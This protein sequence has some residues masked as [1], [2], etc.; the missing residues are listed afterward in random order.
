MGDRISFEE[1]SLSQIVLG[2]RD[3]P[4]QIEKGHTNRGL[5]RMERRLVE[6][7]LGSLSP[8]ADKTLLA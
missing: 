8:L 3:L 6:E 5:Q 2:R 4:Y 7:C 1:T